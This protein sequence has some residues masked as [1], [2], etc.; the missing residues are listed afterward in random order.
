MTA[1]MTSKKEREMKLLVRYQVQARPE[2]TRLVVEFKDSQQ[3]L[4]RQFMELLL[5][6]LGNKYGEDGDNAEETAKEGS[7]E[8]MAPSNYIAG[9]V[10]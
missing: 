3:E 4:M 1:F 9:V 2:L 5:N 10:L 6:A 7:G 8:T